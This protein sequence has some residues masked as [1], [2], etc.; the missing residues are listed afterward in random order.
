MISLLK[1]RIAKTDSESGKKF[2]EIVSNKSAEKQSINEDEDIRKNQEHSTKNQ[3][4]ESGTHQ[5]C[6]EVQKTTRNK[7]MLGLRQLKLNDSSM[8]RGKGRRRI[9]S[10]KSRDPVSKS[11]I[12]VNPSVAAKSAFIARDIRKYFG[13]VEV[14]HENI[15]HLRGKV[16]HGP[17]GD[18]IQTR[19]TGTQNQDN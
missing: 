13:K 5:E 2:W 17:G 10:K 14:E 12:S 4:H 18:I 6:Q 19:N 1:T 15:T 3:E 11:N 9:P 7:H 8:V 16:D